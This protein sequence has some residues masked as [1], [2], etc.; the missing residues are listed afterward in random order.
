M[1]IFSTSSNLV[2]TLCNMKA[3]PILIVDDQSEAEKI[4]ASFDALK[5]KNPI[6]VSTDL[7]TTFQYLNELES[8]SYRK[9]RN[10][11]RLI[12]LNAHEGKD[13]ATQVLKALK[14]HNVYH[15]IPA[16]IFSSCPYASGIEDFYAMGCNGYFRRPETPDDYSRLIKVIYDFWFHTA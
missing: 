13:T 4:H 8:T 9:G 2:Y 11:P 15:S 12:I 7:D 6:V 16:I 10:L 14:T 1:V 5:V 3:W